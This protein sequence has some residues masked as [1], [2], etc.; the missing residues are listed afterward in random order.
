MTIEDELFQFKAEIAEFG[1]IAVLTE[2]F[3]DNIF[4]S[5]ILRK[6][7]GNKE[8]YFYNN[9]KGITG[10]DI[11]K[12][13][14]PIVGS[15][16]IICYDSDNKFLW[17]DKKPLVIPFIYET[18][19]YSFE[20]YS[21]D[22]KALNDLIF[23]M[24]NENFDIQLSFL[25]I[26]TKHISPLFYWWIY[27]NKYGKDKGIQNNQ[28]LSKLTRV[29]EK[30]ESSKK[31]AKK[32]KNTTLSIEESL[33]KYLELD[34]TLLNDIAD[35]DG[36][37]S[38]LYDNVETHQEKIF[39]EVDKISWIEREEIETGID[40]IK[41]DLENRYQI[42]END[43]IYFLRGHT[44]EDTFKPILKKLIELLQQKHINHLEKSI[45]KRTKE[46]VNKYEKDFFGKDFNTKIDENYIYQLANPNEFFTKVVEAI[47]RDFK[48]V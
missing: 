2:N 37:L 17:L 3:D 36:V 28:I 5:R 23:S 39:N 19:V 30:N 48:E 34:V 43:L 47:K 8:L 6:I 20:N 44:I 11:L 38:Q 29:I 25:D 4:W 16:C 31:R 1:D 21:F 45:K 42:T 18:F 26:Y 27:F 33:K 15:N 41:T 10:K 22:G 12:K 7:L 9:P 46:R 13:Y 24:T 32:R 40:Q 14:E 35:L